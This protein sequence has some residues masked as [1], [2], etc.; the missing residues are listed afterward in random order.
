MKKFNLFNE[1]II[2]KK[3]DLL[4]AIN[5]SQE[6]IVTVDGEVKYQPYSKTDVIIFKGIHTKAPM[7]ALTPAK[8]PTLTELFG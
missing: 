5:R 4:N 8:M 2:A 7:S 6:F 1:I 3:A